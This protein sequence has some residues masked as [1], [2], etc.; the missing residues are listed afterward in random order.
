MPWL[1]ELV[2]FFLFFFLLLGIQVS[3]KG[4]QT[5][6]FITMPRPRAEIHRRRFWGEN[7]GSPEPQ[8]GLNRLEMR[9]GILEALV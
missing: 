2:A 4:K 6:V 5:P 1:D 9:Q 3:I 8:T 7:E